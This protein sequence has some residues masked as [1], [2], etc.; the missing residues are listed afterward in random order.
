MEINLLIGLT[1]P[2]DR[3]TTH[4]IAV[5]LDEDSQAFKE[6]LQIRLLGGENC[7]IWNAESS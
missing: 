4:L 5:G 3:L 7:R 6:L 1:I 2:K